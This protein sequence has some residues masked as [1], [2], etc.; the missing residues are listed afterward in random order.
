[1]NP[2][3]IEQLELRGKVIVYCEDLEP[4]CVAL[5]EDG[6]KGLSAKAGERLTIHRVDCPV[7]KSISV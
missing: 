2:V 1:M 3:R 4:N 6:F 7:V 5:S